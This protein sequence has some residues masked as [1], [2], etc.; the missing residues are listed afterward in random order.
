MCGTIGGLFLTV[1][2]WWLVSFLKPTWVPQGMTN[3]V[4]III[5][6]VPETI[7]YSFVF[8]LVLCLTASLIT[9]RRAARQ[10]VVDALT[11]A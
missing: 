9:A 5:Y 1:L 7:V 3:P 10:N 11:H 4:P 8:L 2:S 6:L